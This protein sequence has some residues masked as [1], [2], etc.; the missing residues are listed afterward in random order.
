[1]SEAM[2]L[3]AFKSTRAIHTLAADGLIQCRGWNDGPGGVWVPTKKGEALVAD[4]GAAGK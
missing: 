4:S 2:L 3:R 1:M